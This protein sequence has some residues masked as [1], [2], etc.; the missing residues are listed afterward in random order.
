LP[1]VA[2]NRAQG[3]TGHPFSGK[4]V[5]IIGDTPADIT[6]GRHLGVTAVGV[7]T[8]RYP[9]EALIAAGADYVFRDLTNTNKVIQAILQSS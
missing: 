9:P 4:D 1:A 7:A 2:I 5:V 6:C 8:G 3:L